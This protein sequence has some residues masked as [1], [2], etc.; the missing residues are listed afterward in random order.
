MW[1]RLL[2]L[3]AFAEGWKEY[4]WRWWIKHAEGARPAFACPCVLSTRA[5]A[6]LPIH[7]G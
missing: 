5:I 3:G 4:E 6:L 2:S 1:S 7:K